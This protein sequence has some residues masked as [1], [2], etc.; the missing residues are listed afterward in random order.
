M[1]REVLSLA[2]ALALTGCAT[3]T[4]GTSDQIQ[5]NSDPT[6][7]LMTSVIDYPCGG[8]CPVRDEPIG[9]AKPYPRTDI[10]TPSVPGPSCITP[11]LAQVDRNKPLIVTFTKAGYRPL[12]IKVRT[13]VSQNG[14]AGFAGNIILGGAVGA[15]TDAATG[16][17]M[18]HCP[19]PVNAHLVPIRKG[20]AP[21]ADQINDPCA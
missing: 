9:S 10:K 4:R 6:G 16:A 20:D 2:G 1:L 7:A 13:K 15:V 14:A 11:C 19:N 3:V 8:P 17:A 21:V 18:D 5:F 12:S